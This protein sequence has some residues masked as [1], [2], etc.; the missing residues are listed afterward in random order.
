MLA[1]GCAATPP[2]QEMSDARQAIRAAER[3]GAAHA[4]PEVLA[5]ARELLERAQAGLESGAFTDARQSALDARHHAMRARE[6]AA[7]VTLQ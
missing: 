6:R 2:V 5:Q 1:A 7:A 3:A 4:A